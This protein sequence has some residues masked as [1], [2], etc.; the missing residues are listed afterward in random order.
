SNS[1][2]VLTKGKQ[3]GSDKAASLEVGI[4]GATGGVARNVDVIA[5]GGIFTGGD[6]AHGIF[7]QST[8]GGGGSGGG[9]ERQPAATASQQIV[10]GVGGSGGDGGIGGAVMVDSDADIE[11]EG[12][13]AHGIYAQSVGG[14]GGTGGYSVAVDQEPDSEGPTSRT[15]AVSIGGEGG[16]GSYSNTVDVTNRGNIV[17]HGYE[18]HGINAESTGGGGGAGGA[19][20]SVVS[21]SDDLAQSLSVN[22]G[23]K[24]GD[25][26]TSDD[27]TVLNEGSI[28]TEGD[29]AV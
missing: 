21:M 28:E 27:V 4:A 23:G 19:V 2:E 5:H 12:D 20:L 15:I 10:V 29:N 13:K 18:A 6:E 11:T 25:G 8:G 26:G 7:A 17:T 24:G 22:V 1:V 16:T 9:I 3:E 14:G